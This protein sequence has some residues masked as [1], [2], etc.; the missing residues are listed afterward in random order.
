MKKKNIN[1]KLKKEKY[2]N[3]VIQ[4]V[5]TN[6]YINE[7]K[8]NINTNNFNE[9]NRIEIQIMGNIKKKNE[10]KINYEKKKKIELETVKNIEYNFI[11]KKSPQSDTNL[12]EKE[13]IKEIDDKKIKH[14]FINKNILNNFHTIQKETICNS[15]NY[16]STD[17]N[18]QSVSE[19]IGSQEIKLININGPEDNQTIN[20][21]NNNN[22]SID[23]ITESNN[24][25]SD[26]KNN[27]LQNNN[28]TFKNFEEKNEDYNI[29][30]NIINNNKKENE[31]STHKNYNE[32]KKQNKKIK[33]ELLTNS[34]DYE[35]DLLISP[36][37]S[38]IKTSS[39]K[40]VNNS[41]LLS[42]STNSLIPNLKILNNENVKKKKKVTF[43]DTSL[44]K[45]AFNENDKVTQL[46]VYDKDNKRIMFNPT[47]FDQYLNVL[48]S[49]KPKSIIQGS[50]YSNNVSISNFNTPREFNNNFN[51][52]FSNSFSKHKDSN[53]K[54]GYDKLK[55]ENKRWKNI[56]INNNDFKNQMLKIENNE[57]NN[58]KN[59]K[60]E[61]NTKD[62]NEKI[63]K[64][65]ITKNLNNNLN[66][67]KSKNKSQNTKQINKKS[68]NSINNKSKEKKDKVKNN[69]TK[70]YPLKQIVN[71]VKINQIKK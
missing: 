32:D 35:D 61:N 55:E 28:L 39:K 50:I 12:I 37:I 67:K 53:K 34:Y 63:N 51:C 59:I 21:I 1:N 56:V 5:L 71:R 43:S 25:N 22:F 19:T 33:N 68:E 60:I 40:K 57:E 20:E 29:K 52:S 15:D 7:N 66:I 48:S 17:R 31:I 16:D 41:L 27:N 9:G 69:T 2:N 8:E 70:Y 13:D 47:N 45:I 11:G 30:N 42:N 54:K 26:D 10:N 24:T 49:S 62:N 23:I 6:N 14:I 3:L 64:K 18:Y 38:S 4:N 46:K 65:S 36:I 44:V 58:I